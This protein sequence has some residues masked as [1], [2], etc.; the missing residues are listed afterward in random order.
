L[1]H[2]ADEGTGLGIA[3][4]EADQRRQDVQYLQ[5]QEHF[6]EMPAGMIQG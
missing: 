4:A 1:N 6:D 5:V 3:Q 2:Q